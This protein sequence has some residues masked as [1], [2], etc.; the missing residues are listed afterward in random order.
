MEKLS[1]SGQ[2]SGKTRSRT[3]IALA[4]ASMVALLAAPLAGS[5]ALDSKGFFIHAW[6]SSEPLIEATA[7]MNGILRGFPSGGTP[8]G[9][10]SGTPGDG[11]DGGSPGGSTGTPGG[12]ALGGG[13]PGAPG[14]GPATFTDARATESMSCGTET[15]SVTDQMLKFS[16]RNRELIASGGTPETWPGGDWK[17]LQVGPGYE[18]MAGQSVQL[19]FD[20]DRT[21]IFSSEPRDGMDGAHAIISDIQPAAVIGGKYTSIGDLYMPQFSEAK[22]ANPSVISSYSINLDGATYSAC[23]YSKFE[24]G[25]LSSSDDSPASFRDDLQQAGEQKNTA[26][27]SVYAKNGLPAFGSDRPSTEANYQYANGDSTKRIGYYFPSN[28][29]RWSPQNGVEYLANGS[30]WHPSEQESTGS[31]QGELIGFHTV[32][33]DCWDEDCSVKIDKPTIEKRVDK[34]IFQ[35]R[36]YKYYNSTERIGSALQITM[37]MDAATGKPVGRKEYSDGTLYK[38]EGGSYTFARTDGPA[39]IYYDE[40]GNVYYKE[41]W[42]GGV[43]MKSQSEYESKG[44]KNWSGNS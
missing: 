8:G 40:N 37:Q 12:G 22:G 19:D 33:Q 31:Y 41:Y 15:V 28:G 11:T 1:Q 20:I 9:P 4:S 6:N 3:K 21:Y 13:T 29:E 43:N 35:G 30:L 5:A 14:A 7:G 18:V 38:P 36:Y 23:T 2:R 17:F 16:D 25:K 34:R 10:G 24:N 44:G 32:W 27:S 42:I 39:V 26:N